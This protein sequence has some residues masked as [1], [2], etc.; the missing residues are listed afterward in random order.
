MYAT[1]MLFFIIVALDKFAATAWM[2]SVDQ[3]ALS[4]VH[5]MVTL[6]D[7][8]ACHMELIMKAQE[9]PDQYQPPLYHRGLG[10]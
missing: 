8:P 2:A 3:P 4:I 1:T 7:L 6:L 5:H 9:L 10:I